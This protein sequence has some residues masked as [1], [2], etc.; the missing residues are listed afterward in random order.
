MTDWLDPAFRK[1]V[2][3][4]SDG[5]LLALLGYGEARSEPIE[6]VVS[7]LF[8]VPNRVKAQSWFGSTVREVMLKPQQYSCLSPVDGQRNYERVLAMAAR[9]AAKEPVSAFDQITKQCLA[10]AHAVHEGLFI[11]PT[12]GATHYHTVKMLPRPAWAQNV[13]PS[14]Q[15]GT[16]LFY[17]GVK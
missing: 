14:C 16:H 3:A 10:A 17:K 15:R 5:Q 7:V 8:T 13:I 12:A 2:D 4:L 1:I 11:D 9:F 6:G